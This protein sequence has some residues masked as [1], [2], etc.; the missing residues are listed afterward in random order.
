VE[1][2][3]SAQASGQYKSGSAS[4][5]FGLMQLKIETAREIAASLGMRVKNTADLFR[6][7]VN[8]VLGVAYL[9]QLISQF[10]SFKLGLLAYNQAGARSFRSSR[11]SSRC[12]VSITTGCCGAIT[13][14]GRLR[15]VWD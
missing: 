10:R 8:V 6:P 4:G 7:D 5:A 1:S 2:K 3:F 12:Q 15:T 9:T 13:N 14:S 11:R